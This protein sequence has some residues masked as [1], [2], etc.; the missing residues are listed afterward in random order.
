MSQHA[1]AHATGRASAHA[2]RAVANGA[3][4]PGVALRAADVRRIHD[5][6]RD[7]RASRVA[8]PAPRHQRELDAAGG[9]RRE[10]AL[11]EA[12]GAAVRRVSLPNDGQPHQRAGRRLA[13]K[14]M[15]RRVRRG[16]V[17]ESRPYS[18]C[19]G[20]ASVFVC[21]DRVVFGRSGGRT[22]RHPVRDARLQQLLVEQDE[23]QR[24][25]GRG[26]RQD[27]A[28]GRS[29]PASRAL[30]HRAASACG[31]P[32]QARRANRRRSPHRARSR[33]RRRR[34]CVLVTTGRPLASAS[35]A[36]SGN[37]S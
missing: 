23:L 22:R 14:A 33:A 27:G 31:P 2:R 21:R 8:R 17:S 13:P 5:E 7:T 19:S 32:A 35:M 10:R 3:R 15:R 25:R 12:F 20:G 36:A 28:R 37:E 9:E 24:H 16:S 34:T 4:K 6:R 29:R 18:P 1:I 26:Q 30:P 11:D